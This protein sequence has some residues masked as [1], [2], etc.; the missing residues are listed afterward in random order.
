MA[1]TLIEAVGLKR[2]YEADGVSVDALRGVDLAVEEAEF[3]AVM[4]PSGCGKSTLLHLV[5]ALDTPSAGE[6]RL[7]GRSLGDLDDRAL[8]D[9]RRRA[10][11]IVFQFFNLVPVL[12]V[13]ENVALPAVIDGVKRSERQARV[14]ELLDLV[15][16]AKLASQLPT[17]LSG[18][19]QQRVAIARALM[20]RP[21]I[22]LADEPTGNLDRASGLQ[23]MDL[24]A[25]L[26]ANGQ[27][28]VIVTHDANVACFA[29]RV[30]FMRDGQVVDELQLQASRDAAAVLAKMVELD[31]P[32][33]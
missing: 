18:G 13:A 9:V 22:L 27:T 2:T 3:V 23:I 25:A 32:E 8:T 1:G 33:G 6:I 15:G 14:Q 31:P 24:L 7:E 28:L 4:G 21:R 20:N 19:E 12:T 10:V 16:I 30:V 26:H 29:D 17:R 5:A 11:G